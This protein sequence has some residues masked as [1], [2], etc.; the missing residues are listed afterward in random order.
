MQEFLNW[1]GGGELNAAILREFVEGLKAKGL[2]SS[3]INQR[4]AA[5]RHLVDEAKE[6]GALTPIIAAELKAVKGAKQRGTRAGNWLD[7]QQAQALLRAPDVETLKG[8]RDRAILAVFL[9]CGL[10]RTELAEL[11]LE[12]VQQREGRWALVDITG[13]GGRVRTVP[14]PSWTKAA[15]D[16]WA[17]AATI[18]KGYLF[19]PINKG[20]RVTGE[21]MTDQ[22]VYDVVRT[23][24]D[25]KPHDLRR[26]HAKLAYKGGALLDQIQ[27]VLGHASIATTERYLGVE[28]ELHNAPGDHVGLRL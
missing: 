19:R 26:T 22:G 14:M 10:R 2:G 27:L 3:A 21:S 15:L 6:S 17:K 12:K 24:T 9:G 11:R 25:A 1:W 23:Y 28:L 16:A 8:L 7:K 13:K 4:L 20:G 5:I 18:T